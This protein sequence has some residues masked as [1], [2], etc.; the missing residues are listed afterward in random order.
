MIADIVGEVVGGIARTIFADILL[1]ILIKGPGIL[2][3]RAIPGRRH[4]EPDGAR[5][6]AAGLLFWAIVGGVGYGIYMS[7]Q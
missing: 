4:L 1:E 7:L 3:M 5:V 6:F 2:I